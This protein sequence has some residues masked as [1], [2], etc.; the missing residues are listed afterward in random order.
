MD[1][2]T[3]ELLRYGGYVFAVFA[4]LLFILAVFLFFKL[5][6]RS[7]FY[8][9]SGKGRSKM[10]EKMAESYAVTGTLRSS[11]VSTGQTGQTGQTGKTG[12]TGDLGSSRTTGG[13][14][15]GQINHVRKV[16]RNKSKSANLAGFSIE[17]ELIVVH[18]NERIQ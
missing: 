11:D 4:G 5:K 6:I 10:T 9:L 12:G 7:V 2:S 13:T 3:I 17:K 1:A 14:Q 15:T 18:T 8:E 16:S